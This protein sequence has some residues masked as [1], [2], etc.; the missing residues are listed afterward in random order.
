MIQLLIFTINKQCVGD[1]D[2]ITKR[3]KPSHDKK[4]I[5]WSHYFY[6]RFNK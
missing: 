4:K 3:L 5:V 6:T 2:S 1:D